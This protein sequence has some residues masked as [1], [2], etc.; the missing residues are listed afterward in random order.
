MHEIDLGCI[1]S[2]F[3][4]G[5]SLCIAVNRVFIYEDKLLVFW[6]RVTLIAY[7]FGLCLLLLR[8]QVKLF[9]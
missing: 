7:I 4:T 1:L 5:V 9:N 2:I 3:T 8:H 6:L